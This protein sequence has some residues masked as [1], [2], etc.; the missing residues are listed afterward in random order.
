MTY[1]L[2]SFIASHEEETARK[3]IIEV[4]GFE[5]VTPKSDE[6]IVKLYI[7]DEDVITVKDKKGNKRQILVPE[8]DLLD[9]PYKACTALVIAIGENAYKGEEYEETGAWCKV[10]DFV[11]IPRTVGWQCRYRGHFVHFIK[12]DK[13]FNVI[14]DPTYIK[15]VPWEEFFHE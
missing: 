7:P 13:I 4:M 15:R 6:L 14:E 9:E 2:T 10:G 11:T 8:V 5:V 3:K 12:A 1:S